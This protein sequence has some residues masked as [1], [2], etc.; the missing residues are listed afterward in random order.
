M[1]SVMT[2]LTE[3][4]ALN[5][6]RFSSIQTV[7]ETGSTNSDLLAE[8]TAGAVQG[9]VLVTDHQ[10][11]GRGRQ[12]RS[13]HDD[14]GKA[15]LV[16][17]LLR[18]T[19]TVAPI[20][21]LLAGVA[22]TEAV[23]TF[24][25]ELE[26]QPPVGLKWPNDVLAPGHDER[27]VAGIL[28]ESSTAA[29]TDGADAGLAVVVGMGMNLSWERQPPADLAKKAVTLGE[30]LGQPV[31]RDEVLHRYLRALEYW[32]DRL[33]RFGPPVLLDRYRSYCLTIGRS[34]RFVTATEE[35]E[36]TAV[37]VSDRGTLLL[38]GAGGVTELHA[39][40]AHHRP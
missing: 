23:A 24:Q 4:P 13:W 29:G 39:G 14:P 1:Y 3:L 18:P 16:S 10:T 21:P 20:M 2:P 22:A 37:D 11:A 19:L 28:A 35:L 6:T 27:K 26:A 34:V 7:A 38:E 8:A 25:N 5:Q 32:L 15:L 9:R 30:V 33:E 17:V 12:D 36:G 40:D 31:D